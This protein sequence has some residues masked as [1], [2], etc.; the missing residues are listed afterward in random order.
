MYL[1]LCTD[2]VLSVLPVI[3]AE[4]LSQ[5]FS[6]QFLVY[7]HKTGNTL[8]QP[9]GD[10]KAALFLSEWKCEVCASGCVCVRAV[11]RKCEGVVSKVQSYCPCSFVVWSP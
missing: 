3:S 8:G 11:T 2:L 4:V 7:T 5:V 10:A 9:K 1:Y 6:W